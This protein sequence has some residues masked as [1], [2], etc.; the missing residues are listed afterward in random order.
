[1]TKNSFEYLIYVQLLKFLQ[2]NWE[3]QA[4]CLTTFQNALHSVNIIGEQYSFRFLDTTAPTCHH[5][6][7]SLY[8][9]HIHSISR[10][11]MKI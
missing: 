6:I 1:M 8:T 10:R 2:R 4:N 9:F 7:Y 11:Y 5:I 3:K